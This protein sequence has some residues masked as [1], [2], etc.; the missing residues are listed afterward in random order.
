MAIRDYL[1]LNSK[2]AQAYGDL[3]KGLAREYVQDMEGYVEGKTP[4]LVGILR[5]VGS[6]ATPT[7]ADVTERI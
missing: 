2:A 1:R 6:L 4:F 5:K 3:K 7:Q